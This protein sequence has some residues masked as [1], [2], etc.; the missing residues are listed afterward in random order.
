MKTSFSR[1]AKWPS[2]IVERCATLPPHSAIFYGMFSLDA[3]GEP[4]TE[5][6]T[7]AALHAAANAPL[8][9]LTRD[10]LGRGIVGGSMLSMMELSRNTTKVAL[11]LLAGES[12]R[13]IAP[14]TLRRGT[15]VFDSRDMA[16][17]MAERDGA[18]VITTA[19]PVDALPRP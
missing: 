12:P 18:W 2:Q 11:R 6:Q 10:H 5:T 13:A 17:A 7:L 16:V 19:G 8:F 4:Q 14:S 15:P 3:H 1:P 9:G